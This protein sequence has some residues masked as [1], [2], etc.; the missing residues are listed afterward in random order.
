M[1]AVHTSLYQWLIGKGAVY[2]FGMY[3]CKK[4]HKLYHLFSFFYG[5]P[6]N[7]KKN[8]YFCEDSRIVYFFIQ[9]L[10]YS[11]RSCTLGKKSASIRQWGLYLWGGWCFKGEAVKS[12]K[13]LSWCILSVLLRPL[14]CS[15]GGEA[16]M[17]ALQSNCV[18][19]WSLR[20]LTFIYILG[21]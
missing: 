21:E 5:H 7:V 15:S 2:L 9:P 1:S 17:W 20:S 16:E 3:I 12:Q 18:F 19:H 10:V 4:T 11:F 6:K 13:S 14:L 8:T